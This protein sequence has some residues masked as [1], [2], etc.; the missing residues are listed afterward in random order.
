MCQSC[1]QL[2]ING[3]VTH[4]TGCPDAWRD[5]VRECKWCGGSFKPTERH[6][7][8]CEHSC[9]VAWSGRSCDCESCREY[10]N[11]LNQSEILSEIGAWLDDDNR[12]SSDPAIGKSLTYKE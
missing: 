1:E 8:C 4:E 3:V 5:E 6:Q 12:V 11:S 10:E 7:Y 9:K 2:R